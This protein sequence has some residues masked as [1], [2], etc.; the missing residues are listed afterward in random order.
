MKWTK[1][2]GVKI[3]YQDNDGKFRR[4]APDFL[5]ERQG[6]K[7]ELVEMK[8]YH[9]IDAPNTQKKTE[10]ATKWCKSRNIRYRLVSKHQ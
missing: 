3:E 9:M 6:E 7:I 2:H 10:A 4:Y 5:V 8:A 1:N